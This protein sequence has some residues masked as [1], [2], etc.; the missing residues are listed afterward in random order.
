MFVSSRTDD[1]RY[2]GAPLMGH[3]G[4]I[5]ICH[6]RSPAPAIR[7]AIAAAERYV[8]HDVNERI[9][10]GLAALAENEDVAAILGGGA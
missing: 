1:T 3:P 5:V 7:N 9:A 6:G 4:A 8:A 2:G 10:S